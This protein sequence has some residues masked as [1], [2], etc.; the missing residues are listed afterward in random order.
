MFIIY[1]SLHYT[2]FFS[3]YSVFCIVWKFTVPSREMLHLRPS[4][5]PTQLERNKLRWPWG[6]CSSRSRCSPIA[7]FLCLFLVS[8]GIIFSPSSSLEFDSTRHGYDR[9]YKP[10]DFIA[11]LYC[12]ANLV[13][14]CCCGTRWYAL[15]LTTSE[16]GFSVQ[17]DLY[18]NRRT[19]IQRCRRR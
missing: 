5:V 1:L 13:C 9:F 11:M 14:Q 7:C 17:I 2:M 8:F 10:F 15:G 16:S 12:G 4:A 6:L 19:S 18:D 3:P